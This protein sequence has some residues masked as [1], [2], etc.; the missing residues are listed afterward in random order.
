MKSIPG[1]HSVKDSTL[2]LGLPPSQLYQLKFG[3]SL[4]KPFLTLPVCQ[5]LGGQSLG[6]Q[7][8][9]WHSHRTQAP[10]LQQGRQSL[11]HST[12][13]V[14]PYGRCLCPQSSEEW[15]NY[16]SCGWVRDLSRG[17]WH[18]HETW[19]SWGN[20]ETPG[21]EMTPTRPRG[22]TE[23]VQMKQ[24]SREASARHTCSKDGGWRGAWEKVGLQVGGEGEATRCVWLTGYTVVPREDPDAGAEPSNQWEFWY[25]SNLWATSKISSMGFPG[26][27]VVKDLPANAGDSD[28]SPGPGRSHMPRSN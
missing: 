16:S 27:A 21:R 23:I 11:K 4:I 22:T 12:S 15:R 5:A 17:R 10:S 8:W 6:V 1:T 18:L 25:K 28:S 24:S 20:K 2:D 19:W 9:I 7:S 13:C 14:V 26:G 3:Y